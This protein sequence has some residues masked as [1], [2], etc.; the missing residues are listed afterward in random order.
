MSP[1]SAC[2]SS[3]ERKGTHS[4]SRGE[5]STLHDLLRLNLTTLVPNGETHGHVQ[6]KACSDPGS[7]VDDGSR[8]YETESITHVATSAI[9]VLLGPDTLYGD[10]VVWGVAWANMTSVG[11]RWGRGQYQE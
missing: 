8:E 3:N 9:N 4:A 6:I 7:T 11:Q 5:P 10:V 1:K 2:K